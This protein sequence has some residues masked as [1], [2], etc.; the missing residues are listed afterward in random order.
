MMNDNNP[1][2]LQAI[3]H[4]W[5]KINCIFLDMDGTLLDLHFDNYF[6][7]EHVPK[8]Y[9]T[10]WGISE[11]TAKLELTQR[12]RAIQGQLE[13]Y[14]LDYWRTEL[15]M[16]IVAMKHEVSDRIA[17]RAKVEKFL[18]FLKTDDKQLVL[19]TNA[20]RDSLSLKFEYTAIEG[21]FDR[22]ISAHDLGFAK[23]HEEFWQT[24]QKKLSFQAK[25]SLLIDDNR[26][27]LDNA[28]QW[29]IRYLLGIRQPDSQQAP[30][31]LGIF[32][33]VHCFS[34]LM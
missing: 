18:A 3:R 2:D 27:V 1:L 4:E 21:Y 25:Q 6:W 12:Y 16:D 17:V 34:E 8:C 14:C 13:W 23:E 29:G 31:P 24:L 30:K 33:E 7:L 32:P 26:D 15:E 10:K 22:I 5:S 19:L 9:A 11:Q 28:Y 20:H